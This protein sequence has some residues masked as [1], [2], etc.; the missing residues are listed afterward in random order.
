MVDRYVVV[1]AG[2]SGTRFWPA[3]RR[4]HPKQFLRLGG[5]SS[6][7]RA[8]VERV[9]EVVD[10]DH[11][12]VVTAAV[13]AEHAAHELT[14]LP[15]ENLLIEP[16]GRNTAPCIGWA[17]AEIRSRAPDAIVAVLPADHFIPDPEDFCAHLTAAMDAA[18][19]SIVLLGLVPTAPETGYG[20]I[21]KGE[22]LAE[23][24]G[25]AVHAVAGFV[26]KPDLATAEGY[27]TGGQHLWNSGM[28]VYSAAVMSAAIAKHL[29]DLHAGLVAFMAAG[30]K[31]RAALYP[32]LDKISIDYGV[33][34]KAEGVRVIPSTFAWSDVGSWD[35]AAG[36]RAGDGQGNVLIGDAQIEG[37]SGCFVDA[38]GGRVVAVVGAE[39]LI[40][41]DTVDALLVAKKGA[42]QAVKAIVER[43]DED[44]REGVL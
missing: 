29:P 22:A 31:K 6:L 16:E 41:V 27:L 12:I 14:E 13:H 2:G 10:W 28:F 25:K 35:A 9:L 21:E 39:D 26:E 17:T 5:D 23:A 32:E 20:Y 11:L 1:M 43:L 15:Q 18:S 34:E 7:L 33:M 37:S 38:R 3:S 40:I 4:A 42:S 30:A 8:T 24:Q 19:E 44:G 36:L